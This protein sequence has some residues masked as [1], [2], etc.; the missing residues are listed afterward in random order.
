MIIDTANGRNL[1]N[2]ADGSITVDRL[3]TIEAIESI[4]EEWQWLHDMLMPGS[5]HAD[6]DWYFTSV[7]LGAQPRYPL[8]FAFRKN[9]K[10]MGLIAGFC[11]T[12]EVI[13]KIGYLRFGRLAAPAFSTSYHCCFSLP[14]EALYE[15]MANTLW[16]ELSNRSIQIIYVNALPIKDPLYLALARPPIYK[17]IALA[18]PPARHMMI[19]LSPVLDETIAGRGPSVRAYLR[20]TMKKFSRPANGASFTMR[21]FTRA[22]EL[23]AY[24]NEAEKVAGKTYQRALQVG[25][26]LNGLHRAQAELGIKKGWFRG[27]ILYSG[28]TPVAFQ[29]DYLHGSHCFNPYVGYNPAF[30]DANP[31]TM[32]L[33][34]SWEE[35]ANHTK[36]TLYDFG[37]GE[38]MYKERLSDL[39]I[40][41]AELLL[42]KRSLKNFFFFCILYI[43]NAVSLAITRLL[44]S[45]GLYNAVKK[46]W[47]K[48]STRR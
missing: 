18:Y 13:L 29:E 28:T 1:H 32:L 46:A 17:G 39:C 48:K 23:D 41:E 11:H 25:F 47:R 10:L 42:F 45:L 36:A 34:K 9:D 3:T 14:G 12:R 43:N 7:R 22:D 16:M 44:S 5:I 2:T 19:R 30:R 35:L 8:V 33:I 24:F 4:R 15:K 20:R 38:G 21:L 27:H 26:E 37:F 6:I 40:C 31:G